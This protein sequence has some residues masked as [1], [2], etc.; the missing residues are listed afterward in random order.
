MENVKKRV[1]VRLCNNQQQ[2]EKL[3]RDPLYVRRVHFCNDETGDN[4]LIAVLRQK[5][6]VT[7]DKPMAVGF[8]VLELSKLTMYDY[9]YNHMMPQ[10]GPD[11]A[12]LCFT[13]TD[14]LLYEVKT[15]NIYNDMA[16]QMHHYDTSDYPE[17]HPLYSTV[18]KKVPGKMKD[19][20][21]GQPILQFAALKAK[22]YSLITTGKI[23]K[24]KAKGVKKSV[25]KNMIRHQDYC[26]VLNN[27]TVM[28]HSMNMFRTDKHQVHAITLVKKSLTAYDDKRWL[29]PDG[30]HSY[31]YG[32]YAIELEGSDLF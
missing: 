15:D 21:N 12:E 9:H 5:K 28:R 19:E 16:L 7:L 26:D 6:L 1:D 11:R 29:Y 24:K 14:S 27:C 31:A 32:H 17:D 3:T 10:Y 8:T 22:L 2:Y 20:T 13:D 25:V 18:N 4:V 30:I 23:F